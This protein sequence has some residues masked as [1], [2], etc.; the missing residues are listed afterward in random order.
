MVLK[1]MDAVGYYNGEF[2]PLEE[3]KIPALDRGV[4]FGDGVYEAL[5]VDNHRFFA[6][7]EHLDRLYQSLAF[8]RIPFALSRA[9]LSAVLQEIADRVDSARQQLYFQVTRATA[10]RTHAFPEEG[11]PNLLAFS[12]EVPLADITE[13]RK[14]IVLPDVRWK[15]CNIKT[16]N[17]IP[18][19]LAAQNAKERGCTEVV[20]H[21]N[22]IVTECS[23]SNILMLKDG[24]LVTAPTD[25]QIL[26]GVTRKHF[27]ALARQMNIPVV[28]E[29]FTLEQAYN[30]DELLITST[31]AH[32]LPVCEMEG[33][34][35][36]GKDPALLSRLQNAYREYYYSVVGRA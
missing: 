17:L 2:A 23:S 31:S 20:F 10:I 7:E 22:G 1:N 13:R 29:A 35:V 34:S 24:A 21:R 9:E 32:G 3:L 5:R 33:R 14:V 4:Y 19:V 11:S 12:R 27:L 18:G 28:E 25:E 30:A 16:L 8:L 36:C 15:Y 26:P 6:L